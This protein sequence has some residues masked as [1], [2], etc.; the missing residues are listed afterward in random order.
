MVETRAAIDPSP[1]TLWFNSAPEKVAS[2]RRKALRAAIREATRAA[3]RNPSVKV[4]VLDGAGPTST[5]PSELGG[6]SAAR[7][8][9][10]S[11]VACYTVGRE[12][13]TG[14]GPVK[15]VSNDI[16]RLVSVRGA[17]GVHT[18]DP[19]EDLGGSVVVE[20][21]EGVAVDPANPTEEVRAALDHVPM[22]SRDDL[23]ALQLAAVRAA[24][25]E[26]AQLETLEELRAV[27]ALATAAAA[28]G[29]R[30]EYA[31]VTDS[32]LALTLR[33]DQRDLLHR[34]VELIRTAHAAVVLAT[35]VDR[36][37]EPGS[38][39]RLLRARVVLPRVW[40]PAAERVRATREHQRR[41]LDAARRVGP[42]DA[43]AEIDEAC[44]RYEA[45]RRELVVREQVQK[46]AH[47]VYFAW[48]K[49]RFAE[50]SPR[51]TAPIVTR[52]APAS[53]RERRRGD[54]R[55]ERPV[56][57]PPWHAAAPRLDL[58]ESYYTELRESLPGPAR[59]HLDDLL[60]ATRPRRL[61]GVLDVVDVGPI[62]DEANSLCR[63]IRLWEEEAPAVAPTTSAA[64][65]TPDGKPRPMVRAIG[66]GDLVVARE[67]LVGYD[68]R[69]IAHVENVMAGETKVREHERTRKVEQT[70]EVETTTETESERDLQTTD[71]FELQ[72][73]AQTTIQQN[74][75][76]E[77]GVNT[78]GRYGLT[79][80][81]TSLQ[82]GFQQSK[83]EARSSSQN[84][85]REIVSKAVERTFE[86][87]RELRRLTITEQIRELNRHTL[88]NT[89]QA[90]PASISGIY[91]WVEKLVEVELRQYGT[92]MLV[93]FHIPEPAVSLLERGT[94]AAKPKRPAPFTLSPA[95]VLE[96]NYLCLTERFDAADV[97]PP[98]PQYVSVGWAWASAPSE[99]VDADT[100]EDTV[101]DM[102]AI[103]DGYRPVDG[104]GLISGHP[105]KYQYFDAYMA[106][107]GIGVVDSTG[108]DFDDGEIEF[109]PSLAWPNGVPVSVRAHGHFD[110]TMVA[111]VTL[112]CMRTREAFADWQLATWEQL[113]AAHDV[114]MQDYRRHL[115]EIAL[116]EAAAGPAFGAAPTENRRVEE[117]E[118]RKWAIKAMR[119]A[120]FNFNGIEQVG[121]FQ[122][123]DP[124]GGDLQAAV[125]SL[126]EEAFEWR[127]ASYF[128][129]PYYWARRETWRSR[130]AVESADPK[131]AAFLRAGSA[132][133]VLPVTP[134]YE[135]R[136]LHYL[137]ADPTVDELTR[138][139]G[140]ETEEVPP[141]SALEDL[142]LELLL[143]RKADTSLGSGT[144]SVQNGQR[145]V[146]IN[147]DSTWA[148]GGRDLGRE[149]YL[150]GERYTIAAVSGSAAFDLDE[151]YNG[152]T[153]SV[154]R[155]AT[156]SVPYGPPWVVRVPTSLVVLSDRR[157]DL[158][159]LGR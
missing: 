130:Q 97:H 58:D 103:P 146:T 132:R 20:R 113:R 73:E 139:Q 115:D 77:A 78:S 31:A 155:Y 56:P 100:A 88:E 35:D 137:E 18:V 36:L 101:A 156:G 118:L 89:A 26:A 93:E 55:P 123:V 129:Y 81:D 82:V 3:A 122:E 141:D 157:P 29:F 95:D 148:A 87:V 67:R 16:F 119:L 33:G 94:D 99:D 131:H 43:A 61:D 121:E 57:L 96:T 91:T 42:T 74:F 39:P 51:P 52:P 112:R 79:T 68:A 63:R 138:L 46:R 159:P 53:E 143:D 27:G 109:E 114:R 72:I 126:F 116:Q 44:K 62:L 49:R 98:P 41:V 152:P 14:G 107:G 12:P 104:Y 45:L 50:R 144:L 133:F 66:W 7:A 134:G 111:Q 80:V 71:R 6:S 9:G 32:W 8:H 136:V 106:V 65:T 117:E 147:G 120:P 158:A 25:A 145:A 125:T 24:V 15:P 102:I 75:S 38:V 13:R 140:P 154:A 86:R 92:R 83:S 28:P 70:T 59:R 127:Q 150:D 17:L 34:H 69:E 48:K 4:R 2:S 149:V 1:F 76:L 19:T 47:E 110:K 22:L 153:D 90:P 23:D 135:A 64:P 151:P 21:L 37:A 124:L 54:E 40:R 30:D 142:W 11:N 105:A 84:V 5:S 60:G 128:L 10:R 85:A 108:V